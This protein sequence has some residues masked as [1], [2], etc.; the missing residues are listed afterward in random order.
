MDLPRWH[1]YRK[2]HAKGYRTVLFSNQKNLVERS[3]DIAFKEKLTA[4][5]RKSS[6]P[7]QI[8]AALK[9]DIYRKPETGFI[10]Y[11]TDTL[12]HGIDREVSFYVGDAA[13]R[14]AAKGRAKDFSD[15]DLMFARNAG[16]RF[17][18]PEEFFF[19]DES[20][21]TEW[22]NEI[23]GAQ[24]FDPSLIPRDL[25]LFMPTSSPLVLETQELIVFVGMPGSGK[26]TFA[27]K[28]LEPH[29]YVIVNQDTLKSRKAC[30]RMAEQ[31]LL[32]G[33]SV[34]IDNTNPDAATRKLYIDLCMSSVSDGIDNADGKKSISARCF[35]FQ[36]SEELARHCNVF[37]E[38]TGIRKKVPEYVQITLRAFGC[39]WRLWRG[40][41]HQLCTALW[42]YRRRAIFQNIKVKEASR[43]LK[44]PASLRSGKSNDVTA[45]DANIEMFSFIRLNF[46][47]I[48]SFNRFTDWIHHLL[49][50]SIPKNATGSNRLTTGFKANA[51]SHS[52]TNTN[53]TTSH[54]QT[55]VS[56]EQQQPRRNAPR[57]CK[58]AALSYASTSKR[59]VK[60]KQKHRQE[61]RKKVNT[62]KLQPIPTMLDSMFTSAPVDHE[63]A[64]P[65]IREIKLQNELAR[66]KTG[67]DI[68]MEETWTWKAKAEKE[69]R[70]KVEL[71]KRNTKLER[72]VGNLGGDWVGIYLI[73]I[74]MSVIVQSLIV[75]NEAASTPIAND[76]SKF[77]SNSKA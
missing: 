31:L 13:G 15:S 46:Y 70:E 36:T 50:F 16:L 54:T 21:L 45:S 63:E 40:Q 25:P 7:F 38:Q 74:F 68:A 29:G 27:K 3:M 75:L 44:K 61:K 59:Q 65:S 11:F 43:A 39:C 76:N 67:I 57:S 71:I 49:V 1:R 34:V 22:K 23:H 37:R 10:T 24:A 33:K 42:W 52:T 8:L 72:V 2:V 66:Y 51:F 9:D 41:V 60:G 19:A 53:A 73:Y 35:Y 5:A 69:E 32:E 6:V 20:S 56:N 48:Y 28:Y 26:S 62:L 77:H 64:G 55:A 30:C 17:Y 4:I 18:V 47:G 12:G 58:S 14:P